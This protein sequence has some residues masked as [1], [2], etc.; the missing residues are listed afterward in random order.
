MT[1]SDIVR[2]ASTVAVVQ[3]I[4]D[5]VAYWRIF[6]GETY[7][8]SLESLGRAKWKR[9]KAVEDLVKAKVK[10]DSGASD[11]KKTSGKNGKNEHKLERLE[12]ARKRADDELGTAQA[13]VARHHVT[14]GIWT[15]GVFFI[16]LRVL[17]AEHK[18]KIFGILP[19]VPYS[20]IRRV[21][22]RGL[23]FVSNEFE[24]STDL[25]KDASQACSFL[26]IYF[27]T[28]MSVKYY[29]SKIFG[30]Q[31]P[32]GADGIMSIVNSPVGQN[33]VKSMGFNPEDLK[34]E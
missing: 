5:L 18:G 3:I 16:M 4:C 19:F 30:T 32:L 14:P 13:N 20:I 8:R 9:D 22:G 6:S 26:F 28:S 33:V 7:R 25:V 24:S 12:K 27:L 17:G 31:A 23:E 15:S 10:V 1:A 11:T 34:M 21:T 29:I 2:L